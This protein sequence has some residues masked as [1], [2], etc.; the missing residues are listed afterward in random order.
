[1][2]ATPEILYQN[3]PASN[4]QAAFV[5]DHSSQPQ[6]SVCVLC[7]RILAPDNHAASDLETVS[8][9]GDCQFLLLE[10]LANPIQGSSRRRHSSRSRRNRPSSSESVEDLFSQRFSHMIN[11]VRR[12]QS[13]SS[14][15][16]DQTPEGD[17]ASRSLQHTSSHTTPSD[18]RRWRRVLSDS[19][20]DAFDNLESLYGDSESNVSFSQYRVFHGDS[21][22]VSF[23][24]Y[25]GDSDDGHSF[26]DAEIFV[27]PDNGS[28]FDSDSDIDPMHAGLN[29][30]NWD[31][32]GDGEGEEDGEWEETGSEEETV[33]ITVSRA[34]IPNAII[35]RPREINFPANNFPVRL[36]HPRGFQQ[37]LD[38]LAEADS[39]RM[40]APPASVSF[41]RNLPRIIVSEEHEKHDGLACAVCK[42]SLSVG[43][44]VNQLPC[45][46]LYHPSCILPWLSARNSCPLCR[47][48]LP[49]DDKDYEEGKQIVNSRVGMHEIQEQYASEDGY[50]DNSSEAE[51]VCEL[52]PCVSGRRGVPD[53]DATMNT[54]VREGGADWLFHAA[55]PIVG[56]VGMVLVLWLSKPLIRGRGSTSRCSLPVYDRHPIQGSSPS[57]LNQRGNRGRRWFFF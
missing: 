44:E 36:H 46:H 9:C 25:G 18:S 45:L 7:R 56:I 15:L 54:P 11:M 8:F 12:S 34:G 10:D 20:S 23:S 43:T 48:E 39:S 14:W 28:N 57:P 38:H 37:L 27:H 41:V 32:P 17:A 13:T 55:A 6:P 2:D 1:M 26:L 51:E 16:G 50:S 4:G 40:G 53:V 52:G 24:A 35:S 49:T 42:D 31:D 22:A 3:L 5:V 29:Q 47:Y 33:A 19:E 30:W 21:D